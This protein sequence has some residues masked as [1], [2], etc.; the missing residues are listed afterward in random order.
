MKVLLLTQYYPP[1]PGSASM[2]M[3]ELAEYL[4]ERGHDVTVVTGFPNYPY[5][6]IYNG[7]KM[8]IYQIKKVNGIN[9]IRVPLFT[10]PK[11]RSFKHAMLNYTSFMLSSIYGGLLSKQPNLIYYY[12][13]P[14]F[15][16]F[17]A[18][19]LS[20]LYKSPTIGE[21]NDLWPDAPIALGIIKNKH[22]IWLAKRF[23][24]FVYENTNYLFFYSNTMRNAV[25]MKGVPEG[26]TEI[27]PLWVSTEHFSP[28]PL[29]E[30]E[31]IR[32]QYGFKG[33]FVIMYTG[34]IGLA[35]G[36]RMIIDAAAQLKNYQDILFALV[37]GG[38]EKESLMEEVYERKLNNVI[39]IP[40]QPVSVIP[41]FLSAADVLIAHLA[42]AP[43]RLGTIP[44]KVLAYMSV[45]KP[46]LIAAE[47][48][49][50]DLI[51]KSESGVVVTPGNPEAIARA[52]LYFYENK[53]ACE[54]MGHKGRKYV[55]EYFDKKKLLKR[56]E[57]RLKEIAHGK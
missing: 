13:P 40:F 43:H 23:E 29:E 16:G 10:T 2:R 25:V 48:E 51:R 18:W 57:S 35:Q 14:L 33:K 56:L 54:E 8:H 47:G 11:R 27:Y 22:V 30:V 44:A 31:S 36:L 21:I 7:Y 9:L 5:G 24:R 26:K 42:P 34:N 4:A 6:K 12:S 3:S 37:G 41:Q 39:F 55:Q 15:L 32:D 52:V 20:R 19:L 45:G 38:V 1:E 49:T 46:L 53:G 50:A 28:R 17:S